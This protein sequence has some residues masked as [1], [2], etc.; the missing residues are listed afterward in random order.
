MAPP[1]QY[2][3]KEGTVT[4]EDIIHR[5]LHLEAKIAVLKIAADMREVLNEGC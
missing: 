4:I 1:C 2:S 3:K 5:I